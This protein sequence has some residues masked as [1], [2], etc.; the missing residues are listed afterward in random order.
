MMH[1]WPVSG[2][3]QLA[4]TVIG[5]AFAAVSGAGCGADAVVPGTPPS[6]AGPWQPEPF[7]VD[8]ALL[9]RAIQECSVL[10]DPPA[11][12]LVAVDARGGSKLLVVHAG[13][14]SES[15]CLVDVGPDKQATMT[16][17]GS[18]SGGLNPPPPPGSL[19]IVSG[20][21]AGEGPTATSAVIGRV[22]PGVVRVVV[23]TGSGRAIRA[24]LGPSGW[25]AAWWPSDDPY[26][27]VTAYDA[28]G[29]PTGTAQ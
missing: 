4:A 28:A 19:E 6:L 24:S 17:G 21:T 3:R 9:G 26:G 16:G 25:F 5:L 11:M 10:R 20:T 2:S 14:T 8:Q 15:E 22:G 29:N 13:R 27:L 18:T 23:S 1:P 12:S 7:G